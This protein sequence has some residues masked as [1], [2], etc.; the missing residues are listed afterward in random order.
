MT[1]YQKI[2]NP[3]LFLIFNILFFPLINFYRI[4]NE[5]GGSEWLTAEWL[6]NYNY[7]FVRRGGFGFLLDLVTN[8][9]NSKLTL[10]ILILSFLYFYIVNS[11]LILYVSQK[12]NFISLILLFSPLFLF[13]PLYDIQGSFRKELLGFAIFLYLLKNFKI[14][15]NNYLI[16]FFYTVSIFSSEVNLLFYPFIVYFIFKNFEKTIFLKFLFLF[17]SINIIYIFFYLFF[18]N[19]FSEKFAKICNSLITSGLKNNICDGA[20]YSSSLN[21]YETIQKYGYINLNF[22][23]IFTHFVIL[24]IALLPLIKSSW[25]KKNLNIFILIFAYFLLFFIISADWGRWL[26]IF[27]FCITCLYFIEPGKQNLKLNYLYKILIFIFYSQTW[28]VNHF[29]NNLNVFYNNLLNPNYEL[30][31]YLLNFVN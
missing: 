12:Q 10:L 5:N 2:I 1:N 15:S 13:F 22:D 25:F 19:I 23:S 26:H 9:F 29:K 6:I 24:I 11:V 28:N 4:L 30:Y 18:S 20:L 17:S 14:K 8:N 16:L 3:L 21:L 31:Y 7:G 27:I